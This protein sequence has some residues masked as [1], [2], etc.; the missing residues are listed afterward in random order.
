M[1][2]CM[3]AVPR[4]GAPGSVAARSRACL[5]VRRASPSR[6]WVRRMSPRVMRA[7]EDVGEEAGV[8]S[9]ATDSV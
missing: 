9:P 1:P 7:A 8:A 2:T 6:P 4:S 5:Y 3:S